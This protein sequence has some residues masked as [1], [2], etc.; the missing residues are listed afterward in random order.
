M[1]PSVRVL[2]RHTKGTP[3]THTY[4]VMSGRCTLRVLLGNKK[5]AALNRELQPPATVLTSIFLCVMAKYGYG[6][7]WGQEA[8]AVTGY[9]VQLWSNMKRRRPDR[10]GSLQ[11]KV[12]KSTQRLFLVC[13]PSGMLSHSPNF[14]RWKGCLYQII[15]HPG[16]QSS[17][18]CPGSLAPVESL[19]RKTEKT[20]YFLCLSSGDRCKLDYDMQCLCFFFH[21]V[22]IK[23]V[24]RLSMA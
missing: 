4:M 18:I 15:L 6:F 3:P 8:K 1:N 7:G 12:Q 16:R 23:I 9:L 22:L 10:T 5:G 2:K 17:P 19:K 20:C 13:C 24:E 11:S 14:C 21:L